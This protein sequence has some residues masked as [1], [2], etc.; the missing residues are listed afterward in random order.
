MPI[1]GRNTLDDYKRVWDKS[2]E[3][4]GENEVYTMVIAG[5]GEDDEP[6][7]RGVEI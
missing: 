5:L 6:M 1:K 2:L 3:I 7:H 4:F